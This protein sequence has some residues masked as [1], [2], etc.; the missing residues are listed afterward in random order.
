MLASWV[1]EMHRSTH[2][3]QTQVCLLFF[4]LPCVRISCEIDPV[5]APPAVAAARAA[6]AIASA[7]AMRVPPVG[8][9]RARHRTPSA[10]RDLAPS[11]SSSASSRPVQP[12]AEHGC[13]M[14]SSATASWRRCRRHRERHGRPRSLGA[15]SGA[16]RRAP[17][18]APSSRAAP[19][20]RARRTT[21]RWR[22]RVPQ[23]GEPQGAAAGGVAAAPADRAGASAP[24]PPRGARVGRRVA[25]PRR[26]SD[27]HHRR[28]PRV[29][30]VRGSRVGVA[31]RCDRGGD[32]EGG[33]A[34][35]LRR[36]ALHRSGQLHHS[37]SSSSSS[38]SSDSSDG[39]SSSDSLDYDE[40]CVLMG[41]L[42]NDRSSAARF[43]C[44]SRSY[45]TSP[46]R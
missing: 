26:R 7:R 6:A 36:R 10:L 25:H 1:W 15:L 39:G 21:T 30:R 46:S 16:V 24:P 38:S 20:L 45:W 18:T 35:A 42:R 37:S 31:H 9:R 2:T 13:A 17:S 22:W 33:D 3:S 19:P 28:P 44:G 41:T 5:D 43:A 29:W 27:R 23:A 14:V 34:R 12:A 32:G 11:A 4:F 8:R 40:F